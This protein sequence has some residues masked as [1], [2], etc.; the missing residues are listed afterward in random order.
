MPFRL[1]PYMPTAPLTRRRG[2]R[3]F[4]I[5]M[6]TSRTR[7]SRMPIIC[8]ATRPV[9]MTR[10]TRR[11]MRT[12]P[13]QFVQELAGHADVGFGDLGLGFGDLGRQ[14]PLSCQEVA[15]PHV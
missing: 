10:S 12:R 9:T 11:G 1:T 3:T 15:V 14:R 4:L 2:I 5:R 7:P 13:P 6:T 8:R